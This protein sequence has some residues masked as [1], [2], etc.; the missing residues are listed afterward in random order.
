MCGRYVLRRIDILRRAL[1]ATLYLPG[2]EEFDEKRIVPRFNVAPAQ[3]CP[4]V[5][6]N[7]KG[8]RV[9]NFAG[10]GLIPSW[11]KGKPKLQ[12]IN[13][14][15]ET[16]A[17]SGMFR[18]AF[19]RRRCLIPADG[20]YE[21][22]GPKTVKHRPW[23][24]FQMRDAAPFAFGGLWERWTP[25][26]GAEPV[27]TFTMLTTAPNEVVGPYH[28]RMPL[29][30]RR[31]DYAQ[32]LDREVPAEGVRGLLAPYKSDDMECWRV[33]DAVKRAGNKDGSANDDPSMIEPIRD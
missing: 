33:G 7:S 14:K 28:D 30:L 22:K 9:L 3:Q 21:P 20:F 23:Y 19:E 25:E 1:E 24:F 15:S 31:E 6:T 5:R 4:I 2:F 12:P 32:W 17:S 13:A 26:P 10:W 27:D 8:Q 29:I 18:P 16:A 11:T